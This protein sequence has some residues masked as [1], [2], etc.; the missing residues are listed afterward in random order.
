MSKTEG[1]KFRPTWCEEIPPEGSYRS[2]LKWGDPKEFKHPNDR[3]YSLMKK[4][5]KMT[6]VDFKNTQKIG[7]EKVSFNKPITLTKD[8]I[9]HF[10]DIVGKENVKRDDYSRLQV[11]YGK[12]MIDLMR[13]REGIVENIPDIVIHPRSKEDIEKIVKYCNEELIPYIFMVEVHQ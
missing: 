11:A 7:I 2:I 3:L 9:K 10:E 13:L 5:F 8:Q 6:D 1:N 12:T 4:T